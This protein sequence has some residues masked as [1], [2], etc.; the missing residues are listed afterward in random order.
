MKTFDHSID[1]LLKH[2]N[3]IHQNLAGEEVESLTQAILKADRI[4]VHGM[5]R[6]GLMAKA[7][8]MR[9]MHL[10]I[11]VHVVGEVTTPSIEKR[12]LLISVSSSGETSNIV[13]IGK[14]AKKEGAKLALITSQP[15]SSLAGMADIV[16][17]VKEPGDRSP[18]LLGTLFETAILIILDALV[19]EMMNRL[20]KSEKEMKSRHTQLE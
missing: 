20:D 6:S 18:L 7:F 4:F 11:K 5:G 13:N 17:T 8:A 9:L 10:G 3:E 15:E 19:V 12:D 16:L 14:I 2:I 1:S